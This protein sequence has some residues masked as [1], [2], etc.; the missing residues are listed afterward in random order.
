MRKYSSRVTKRRLSETQKTHLA[1][2]PRCASRVRG[3]PHQHQAEHV[4][5]KIRASKSTKLYSTK[6]HICSNL[7]NAMKR[8][9]RAKSRISILDTK[10][11][12]LAQNSQLERQLLQSQLNCAFDDLKSVKYTLSISET[13]NKQLECLLEAAKTSVMCLEKGL[14]LLREQ[15]SKEN[16]LVAQSCSI[17]KRK[18]TSIQRLQSRNRLL[19]RKSDALRKRIARRQAQKARCSSSVQK[20][21]QSALKQRALKDSHGA[22]LP[23]VRDLVRQLASEQ[24]S[25]TRI[26]PVISYVA[27]AFGMVVVDSLSAR[28]VSRIMLEGLLQSKIQI[29][30]EIKNTSCMCH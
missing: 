20:N 25:T 1:S 13:R 26:G 18:D 16:L 3:D 11:H 12:T 22:F 29:A 10:L 19:E 27:K 8:E 23:E 24:V 28:S 21:I 14:A 5:K 2:L 9:R 4:E 30:M 6:A 15:T 17:I 7:L